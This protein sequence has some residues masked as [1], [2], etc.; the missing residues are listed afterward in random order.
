MDN[1]YKHLVLHFDHAQQPK[2]AERKNKGYVEF[3]ESNDYPNYLLSLYNE[4]VK[5]GSIVKAKATYIFGHG[6]EDSGIAN[7]KYET[8][9]NLLKKCIKDDEL[10]RGYYLQIIW[11]RA[12][13]ISEV[14]HIDFSKVRVSKD[15]QKFFVKDSWQDS[16]EKAREYDAFNINNPVGAQIFYYK[17]YNPVSECYPLPVYFQT[18]N[19]IE[20]D[21]SVSRHILGMAKNGFSATTMVNLN[22]GDPISEEHKGEVE[23]GLLKKFTGD[24]GKRVIIMF[25]KSRENSAEILP[26]SNTM[27]T[28]EDFTNINNLIQQEIFSG[29]QIV[30]PT[31]MGITTS[32]SLGQ[33]N[34]IRDAYE[35]LN[36]TYIQER[37]KELEDIFT[38]LRNL[39]GEIGEFNIQPVEPLQFQF[40]EVIM[41][42][43]LTQDEIRSL[44]GKEPIDANIKTQA[45]LISDNLNSLSP[46]VATKVL[47][48]MTPNEIRGLAGLTPIVN[49]ASNV[50]PNADGTITPDASVPV[51]QSNDAIKNLSG[52]QYQNVMRIVR[53]FANNKL[54]KA[55]ASLMLKN[56]FNF[57]DADVNTFLGID[58]SPITDFEIQKFSMSDEERAVFEFSQLGDDI[59]KYQI[60]ETKF[61]MHEAFA[62]SSKLTQDEA[63]VLDKITKDKNITPEVIAD[64]LNISVKKVNTI[65]DSLISGQIISAKKSAVNVNPEYKVLKP[66]S[67]LGGA[68]AKKTELY[69]RY[70]YE[71]RTP[72]DIANSRPFCKKML[73]LSQTRMW[74]RADIELISERL[75][76]SV[77]DRVGGW[78]GDSVQ[79]RHQWV[80]HLVT[81]K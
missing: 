21:I 43:N 18:L 56:G 11:N 19:Y 3:G 45:Q 46:L 44:M 49:T 1:Q 38:K 79:C 54:T 70:S 40:G 68:N 5:H 10:F 64:V 80:S 32:G 28:K 73:E 65:I 8:W 58:E 47:E 23:R 34:E 52:R 78:W 36:K 76:Y 55:Q 57:T 69:I 26:L 13:K 39:K 81:L 41:S 67:E 62:E 35:I 14:Y 77:W 17:E 50:L 24:D 31:L 20:S 71:W 72:P 53:Q 33:R 6:F 66:I 25:N 30:S 59:N 15:L 51:Q 48:S 12:K 60:L 61:G 22:N 63:N 2:F 7:S 37:Q 16:R 4:S 29:H 27:L 42:Q 9:N 75:G 74:S